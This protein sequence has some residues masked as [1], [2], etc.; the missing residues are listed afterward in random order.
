MALLKC[1]ECG[2]EVSGMATI[3]PHCGYPV[4]MTLSR[5]LPPTPYRN[6]IALAGIVL[7]V[8]VLVF[9]IPSLSTRNMEASSDKPM[10]SASTL[11]AAQQ[12]AIIATCVV[13][14]GIRYDPGYEMTD[15]E[16]AR[17]AECFSQ[18]K[19]EIE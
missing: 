1:A 12:K 13:D 4:H 5:Q 15:E 6:K 14:L 10:A 16:A 7:A 18:R 9:F 8:L 2:Q 17:V 19:H 11:R 3:C